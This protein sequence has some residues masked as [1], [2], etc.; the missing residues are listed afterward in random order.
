VWVQGI[1]GAKAYQ[2]MP[3]ANAILM[4]S[5]N[6]KRFYIK[7]ADNVGMCTLRT[8]S[9]EEITETPTTPDMSQYVTRDELNTM[10]QNM[11]GGNTDEQSI[12]TTKPKSK[13]VIT[14]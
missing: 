7:V 14:K 11:L 10:L 2:L 13:S 6:D 8:F 5:E 3:N 1:E 12:P 4:D 9:Y